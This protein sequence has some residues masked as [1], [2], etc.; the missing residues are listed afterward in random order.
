[1][2]AE[3]DKRN[4]IQRASFRL[5][6]KV[7]WQILKW[8]GA[9]VRR[10]WVVGL[11]LIA[12]L[13]FAYAFKPSLTI[14]AG[15]NLDIRDPLRTLI[16]IT[17]VG[18][19]R[20]NKLEFSCILLPSHN[21]FK[22]NV[23]GQEPVTVLAPGASATRDCAAHSGHGDIRMKIPDPLDLRLDVIVDYEWPFLGWSDQE[24]KH[25]S[26]RQNRNTGEFILVPDTEEP[27]QLK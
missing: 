22:S 17:N 14:D 4:T 13:Q 20:L 5:R 7:L 15:P 27:P 11:S 3:S 23:P 9:P 21:K 8:L 12:I 2:N 25:F 16:R 26:T 24:T 6:P 19:I 10:A 18:R 1:M